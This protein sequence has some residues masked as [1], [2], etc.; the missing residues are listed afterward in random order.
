MNPRSQPAAHPRELRRKKAGLLAAALWLLLVPGTVVPAAQE[1]RAY[2][3]ALESLARHRAAPDWL[4]DAKLGIYFHWGVYSVPAYGNEW[5]PR[6]MHFLAGDPRVFWHHRVHYGSPKDFAY[7]D[8]VP[9]FTAENFD[10]EEWA[11]LF[12]RAGARFAGPVAEHHD[13]FAMWASRVTPW[14]AAEMGP[15]RDVVG[16]LAKAIRARGMKFITTFHHARN[17]QRYTD[18]PWEKYRLYKL[19]RRWHDSH[20]PYIRGLAPASDDPLLQ[21]LYGNM[22]EARWLEQMWLGKLKEVVDNYRPDIIYFD[23]WLDLIPLDYRE[24]F[25]A[26]Y[27][28]SAEQWDKEVVIARKQDDLP[29]Q[30]SIADYEK[31]RLNRLADEPWLTDDTISTGSWSY[32][33][34]LEIK[35]LSEVLHVFIDIVSKNGQLLLNISPRADGSIPDDQ[36]AVLLGLGDWL[37]EHGESIYA[38]RPFVDFGEGPTRMADSGHFVERIEYTPRD[39]RYTRRG[40]T[41]YAIVLGS[42]AAGSELVLGAFGEQG[43]AAELKV[44][45]LQ[46]LGSDREIAWSREKAGIVITLPQ[47]MPD[48]N[49]NAFRIDTTVAA[50]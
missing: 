15:K 6:H 16:E 20:Y 31:G 27:L 50:D 40:D 22:P 1:T 33:G 34:N 12:A 48:A 26:Y 47:Q 35:S 7:H 37:A 8:F 46:L 29:L 24:A 19:H 5:Y 23:S 45:R 2:Q 42:P 28:N 39:V 13:G 17:L 4:R 25:V 43:K 14:N 9:L 32:T 21:Q 18:E 41:V 49:A 30:Y 36:R 3:P 11:E 10:P 38:T 44:E